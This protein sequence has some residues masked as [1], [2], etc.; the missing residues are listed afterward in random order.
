MTNSAL[1]Y[2]F[3]CL[4]IRQEHDSQST[5]KEE[6]TKPTMKQGQKER[7]L[8]L[9]KKTLNM[10]NMHN[11]K[12]NAVFSRLESETLDFR[13]IY[14]VLWW[15]FVPQSIGKPGLITFFLREFENY[16]KDTKSSWTGFK[17][18]SSEWFGFSMW[19]FLTSMVLVSMNS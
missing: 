11:M 16:S 17:I 1:G 15:S 2:L 13:D 5:I 6:R 4:Y 10:S 9:C 8:G 7:L 3:P 14:I 12:F 19:H 18:S